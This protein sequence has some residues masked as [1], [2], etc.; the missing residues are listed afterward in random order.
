MK[1]PRRVNDRIRINT[2]SV[3]VYEHT[4]PYY[5]AQYYDRML[6]YRI[7]WNTTIYRYSKIAVCNHCRWKFYKF[8]LIHRLRPKNETLRS[9]CTIVNG[10][11]RSVYFHRKNDRN[12]EPGNT[13]QYAR[14][15]PFHDRL[16]EY[17]SFVTLNLGDRFCSFSFC[18]GGITI[19]FLIFYYSNDIQKFTMIITSIYNVW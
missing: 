5:L 3:V 7:R 10:R 15:R 9:S 6:A 18:F 19:F 13:D 1:L 4:G 2:L 16:R 12:T 14:I 17:T 8:L 11:I